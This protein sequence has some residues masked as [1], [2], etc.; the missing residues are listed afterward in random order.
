[1]KRIALFC[2]SLLIAATM[3]FVSCGKDKEP[4]INKFF[5]IDNATLIAEDM[6]EATC[7]KTIDVYLNGNVIPGGTSYVSVE[8]ENVAK[9][10]LIGLKDQVGY[11]ELVLPET[12]DRNNSYSFIMYIDQEIALPDGQDALDIMVAVV[13]ENGDISQIWNAPVHIIEVGTGGLQVSLSFDNAKDVDLHLIEPDYMNEWGEQASFYDRHIYYSN[14]RSA[15]GG[16]LDLDSNP[17]CSLDYVNN[18]NIT[19]NDSTAFIPA[20]TYKVYV[21]MYSNCDASVATNYV[22]TVFYGGNLIATKSG[23]FEIDAPST[24][25]PISESYVEEN[26]PFLTFT[27]ANSGQK[28]LKSF[29]PAPMT[30]SA[31]EK[32]ANAAHE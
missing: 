25:N 8:T 10:V 23:I 18:E 2:G 12:N 31:I 20:G 14:R 26:E 6:P 27:I 15:A 24:Y 3:L 4:T 17:G 11:W 13:D 21:D 5:K 1:M 22:V 32:E 28:C 29:A 19:Y 7:D 9:K 30:E 16:E